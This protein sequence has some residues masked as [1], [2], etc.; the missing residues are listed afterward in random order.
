MV[1]AAYVIGE[2]SS[3]EERRRVVDTLWAS[4][5]ELLVLIEPGTPVGSAHILE[6]RRQVSPW[7]P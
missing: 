6:A 7:S 3:D 1:T 2:L 5:G 4:T